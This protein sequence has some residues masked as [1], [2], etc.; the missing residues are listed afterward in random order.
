MT[1]FLDVPDFHGGSSD[2]PVWAPDGRSIFY[3]ALQGGNVELFRGALD[4]GVE[5]LTRSK[6]GTLHYHPKPS[7]DGRWLLY[8]AKTDGIRQIHVMRLRDHAERRVTDLKPGRAAMWPDWRPAP[9][10]R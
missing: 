3:T 8:G 10:G 5:Q 9:A 1:E 7:S 6:E 2:V 4:G